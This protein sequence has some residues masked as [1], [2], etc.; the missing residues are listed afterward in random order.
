MIIH[1][2]FIHICWH[3]LLLAEEKSLQLKF[4]TLSQDVQLH[5]K[6]CV[7]GHSPQYPQLSPE[8]LKVQVQCSTIKAWFKRQYLLQYK[9]QNHKHT[10]KILS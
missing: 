7:P 2:F 10:M 1:L 8:T 5:V 6:A 4:A 3:I 9:D